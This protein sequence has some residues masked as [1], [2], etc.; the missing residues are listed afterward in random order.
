MG[1]RFVYALR[2]GNI[3]GKI[4]PLLNSPSRGAGR[5]LVTGDSRKKETWSDPK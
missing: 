5:I 4:L 2:E 3:C 1:Q